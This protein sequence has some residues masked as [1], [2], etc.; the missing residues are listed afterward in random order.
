MTK[1]HVSI[2]RQRMIAQGRCPNCGKIKK[3]K[4]IDMYYCFDCRKIWAERNGRRNADT[5]RINDSRNKFDENES[6]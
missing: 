1:E 2:Y 3:G 5:R 6:T 4:D